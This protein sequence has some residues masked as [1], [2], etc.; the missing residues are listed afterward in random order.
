MLRTI[1]LG[2][3]GVLEEPKPNVVVVGHGWSG[4]A[5]VSNIDHSKYNVVVISES[6][7]LDTSCLVSKPDLRNK[8]LPEGAIKQSVVTVDPLAKFV[9]AENMTVPYD[10][11]VLACGTVPN[12]FNIPGVV[13]HAFFMKTAADASKFWEG[14]WGSLLIVGGGAVGLELAFEVKKRRPS[15]RVT[16]VEAAPHMLASYSAAARSLVESELI[17]HSIQFMK[18]MPVSEVLADGARSGT[19]HIPAQAVVWS[20]GI[21]VPDWISGA[22]GPIHK[23]LNG[24]QQVDDAEHVYAIGDLGGPPNAQ[25]AVQQGKYL[26]SRFNAGIQAEKTGD[27]YKYSELAKLVHCGNTIVV[28]SKWGAFMV[29]SWWDPVLRLFYGL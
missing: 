24:F 14:K 18:G 25:N 29:P 5:F 21:K 11:L 8:K 3:Y 15:T 10:H 28:D 4:R 17:A 13:E 22:F 26:A 1:L 19:T 7:F 9:A 20:S 12:T 6:G 16:I 27:P 23:K 2:V